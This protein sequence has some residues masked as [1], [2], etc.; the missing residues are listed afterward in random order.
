MTNT[1][2]STHIDHEDRRIAARLLHLRSSIGVT[3]DQLATALEI[4][5]TELEEY[6]Y[7]RAPIPASLLALAS[8]ALGVDFDYFYQDPMSLNISNIP[9]LSDTSCLTLAP[10]LN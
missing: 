4:S 7:A 8:L 6:E 9:L 5:E 2:L 3:R 1:I 10:F